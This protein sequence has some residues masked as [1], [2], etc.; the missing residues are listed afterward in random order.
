VGRFEEPL[1]L[2][3]DHLE[4]PQLTSLQ[5]DHVVVDGDDVI[6][7]A[8]CSGL[9]ELVL[10]FPV[11]YADMEDADDELAA[12]FEDLTQLTAL[13]KLVVEETGL[14]EPVPPGVWTLTQLRHLDFSISC[15]QQ[16]LP[17]DISCLKQLT[18][19]GLSR[20]GLQELPAELGTWLPQLEVLVVEGT[21]V[22]GVP[23]NLSRLTKLDVS[24]CGL[25]SIAAIEHLTGLKELQAYPN[26]GLDA[27]DAISKLTGLEVLSITIPDGAV[28]VS[29]PCV[30]PRLRDLTLYTTDTVRRAAQ[31]VGPGQHLTSLWLIEAYREPEQRRGALTPEARSRQDEDQAQAFAQLGVL[32]ALQH[33]HLSDHDLSVT[34]LASRWL[35]Q[36][37]QL[38]SLRLYLLDEEHDPGEV[39]D[40]QQLPAGLRELTL[41]GNMPLAGIPDVS[42]QL[43]SLRVLELIMHEHHDLPGWMS[44]LTGL[45]KVNA[46]GGDYSVEGWRALSPLPLLRQWATKCM[47]GDMADALSAAPHLCWAQR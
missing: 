41:E 2:W 13:T 4:A 24:G 16:Q 1:P 33:L 7:L 44:S 38:T 11:D 19:L 29:A 36:Q 22:T 8:A 5:Y 9:R 28:S 46:W 25:G 12:A 23:P 21:R 42:A 18:Y 40:L 45:A 10:R 43:S 39:P 27:C 47:S 26:Y 31:L 6:S 30:L 17:E 37:P 34:A 15:K 20:S 35:Q 3:L 32:P 14:D